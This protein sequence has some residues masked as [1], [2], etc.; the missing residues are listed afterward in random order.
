MIHPSIHPSKH[1][2][3]FV[4]R[5][6]ID[7]ERPPPA[8]ITFSVL[9]PMPRLDVVLVGLEP[10]LLAGEVVRCTLK[11]RNSGAM[12]LQ[13]LSMAAGMGVFLEGGSGVGAPSG[14]AGALG[15]A[16]PLSQRQGRPG[17]AVFVLP[18]DVRLDVG[19]Q[20]ELPVWLR[21]VTPG[22][23]RGELCARGR[24]P[25]RDA[26][27]GPNGRAVVDARGIVA[28]P[29]SLSL[30]PPLPLPLRAGARPGTARFNM[31]W[32]Y[33]PTERV[34]SLRFRTLR[35][36]WSAPSLPCLQLATACVAGTSEP[37]RCLLQ[38]H[39]LN[40]QSREPLRL[41]GVA[42]P[43][44]RWLLSSLPAARGEQPPVDLMD[45]AAQQS[46]CTMAAWQP[47]DLAL[48]PEASATLH[49]R[50]MPAGEAPP[51]EPASVSTAARALQGAAERFFVEQESAAQQQ[52]QSQEHQQQQ[53]LGT[54][55]HA[56]GPGSRAP[57]EGEMSAPLDLVVTWE[58]SRG[59]T[60]PR[61]GFSAVHGAR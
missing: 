28:A 42:C 17:E 45:A 52:Q 18:P 5:V 38:L 46:C 20:V 4:C 60:E 32:C 24:H 11:L 61:R 47:L 33:S 43:G 16:P 35:C 48:G 29:R 26:R 49:Y 9:P 19:Q 2:P 56:S 10:T 14:A 57:P 55:Q 59:V 7:V 3:R 13:G 36:S 51:A 12:A 1:P 25:A 30:H 27:R 22:C 37:G 50:L 15:V 44:G 21:W 31:A 8:G 53:Q 41:A 34:D 23:A 54:Q 39:V 6:L 58:V 40:P